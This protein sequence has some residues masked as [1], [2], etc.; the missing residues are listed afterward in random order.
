M[1][2][3]RYHVSF[4]RRRLN[5]TD[6]Y[7]RRT[8]MRSGKIRLVVRISSEYVYAQLIEFAI[9]GDNVL[10]SVCSKELK[11]LGWEASYSNTSAAY[12]TGLLLGKKA[13]EKGIKDAILD[14]G[15]KRPSSGAKIFAVLKGAL[16]AGLEVPHDEQILP[17]EER[18]RGNHI[19]SY[20]NILREE[21][22]QRYEKLFSTYLS[23]GLKPEQLPERFDDTKKSILN[24][25][26][27]DS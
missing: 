24:L 23:K 25:S 4:R 14:I 11:K 15:L 13:C 2:G 20:A 7:T 5:I 21:D 17:T 18:L 6:Y 16:D 22:S 1:S 8:M 3:P 19:A 9:K 26:K 12:L 27:G 10:E